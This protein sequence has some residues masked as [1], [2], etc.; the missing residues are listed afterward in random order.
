[1]RSLSCCIALVA[2]TP[3]DPTDCRAFS[4][5]SPSIPQGAACG[6][7]HQGVDGGQQTG[8]SCGDSDGW[9]DPAT[10][11]LASGL[12]SARDAPRPCPDGFSQHFTPEHEGGPMDWAHCAAHG[13]P[14]VPA[15]PLDLPQGAVCGLAAEEGF[16]LCEG[17]YPAT[18]L[19]CPEG[20]A[21]RWVPD[22][23]FDARADEACTSYPA[24]ESKG[25]PIKQI[26]LVFF[27]QNEAGCTGEDCLEGVHDVGFLCGLH[28]PPFWGKSA[29]EQWEVLTQLCPEHPLMAHDAEIQA[30]AERPATCLGVPVEQGCPDGLVRSCTWD[31]TAGCPEYDDNVIPEA[32]CWCAAPAAVQGTAPPPASWQDPPDLDCDR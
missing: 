32:L 2:C 15:R 31:R 21:L 12:A 14:Q 4:D 28:A 7:S 24:G 8:S 16:G 19:A 27:C 20:W 5:C 29:A 3:L 9:Y 11:A 23:F 17:Y 22:I 1:M 26:E 6:F 18:D 25:A 30:A 10:T 13:T